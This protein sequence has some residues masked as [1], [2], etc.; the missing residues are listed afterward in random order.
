MNDKNETVLGELYTK[1]NRWED[2]WNV[3]F[4][5][6]DIKWD[7]EPSIYSWSKWKFPKLKVPPCIMRFL[8]IGIFLNHPA[9]EVPQKPL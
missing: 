2:H 5:Q 9:I 3:H 4:L 6:W 8:D 7:S 1:N